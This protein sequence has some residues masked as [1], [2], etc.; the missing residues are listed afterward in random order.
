MVSL[1][2][3]VLWVASFD[4]GSARQKRLK[5]FCGAAR[6]VRVKSYLSTLFLSV[7]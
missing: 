1:M 6:R 5:L 4:W 7:W 2:K 3:R